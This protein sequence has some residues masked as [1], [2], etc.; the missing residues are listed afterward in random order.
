MARTAFTFLRRVAAAIV[1]LLVL[2][3]VVYFAARLL[4]ANPA[5]AALG[6]TASAGQVAR[7]RLQQGLDHPAIVGYADWLRNVLSGRWGISLLSQVPVTQI[8]LPRLLRTFLLAVFGF[9][10]GSVIAVP[11]GY[12]AGAKADSRLDVALS[13]IVV[14]IAALPEFVIAVVLLVI[15]AVDL[16][17]LPVTSGAILSG[18][19]SAWL[20]YV[21]P[22]ASLGLIV[23]PQM[24][25]Q[26][27]ITV[28][29]IMSEPYVAAARLRG[30]SPRRVALRYVVP[31]AAARMV[32]VFTLTLASL[33]TGVVVVE[34][35]FGY[36][37]VGQLL[38]TSIGN[39]DSPVVEFCVMLMG[40]G[41]IV[42][43][44]LA[45]VLVLALNPRLRREG[46]LAT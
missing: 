6:K 7:F 13:G 15:F 5:R 16:R 22:A 39:N 32:N 25:R 18:G 20:A 3:A 24:A 43:N 12:I 30:V 46:R 17:L 9:C 44:L 41:Y 37:G 1:T 26:V 28:S 42:L 23:V 4:P 21:L 38:I 33:F 34:T 19:G 29:E 35:V 10:I 27:R 31:G 14:G 40:A 11:L 2:S 45:D 8:A 36:P